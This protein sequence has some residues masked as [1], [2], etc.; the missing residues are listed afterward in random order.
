MRRVWHRAVATAAASLLAVTMLAACGS[1]DE[2][3]AD[4]GDGAGVFPVTIESS[5][6]EATIESKPKRIVTL[7][8]GSTETAIALGIT[9]VGIE[10]YAWGSDDTGYLPWVY[11]A[12]QESGDE[13]PEQ[14][15]GGEDL[16]IDAIVELDPDVI[17]APWS[18][19]SQEQFDTLSQLAPVVAYPDLAWS[20]DWDEQIQIIGEAVGQPEDAEKLIDEIDAQFA[21]VA[22]AHPE[23]ADTTFSFIYSTPETLGVFMPNEQRVAMLSNMGL[24]VDPVVETLEEAEGTDSAIIGYENADQLDN[25]DVI[26]TFYSDAAAKE[27]ALSNPLYASI[28][29][30]ES[31]AVVAPTE[32]P[33][34]TGSSIVNP[35]TVPWVLDKYTEMI[36]AAI[37]KIPA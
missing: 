27:D 10:E 26:F 32:N 37:A 17:L 15:T 1:G 30:I 33:F 20:T 9:P 13:L 19:I 22:Q 34:V 7:G 11:E 35:L 12:V 31:D 8:Q 16:D 24:Q 21:E 5:L 3:S 36:D 23:Y 4:G 6:G 18:G 25:S 28:P 2:G 14:F 29:A